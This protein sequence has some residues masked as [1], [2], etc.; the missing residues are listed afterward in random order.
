MEDESPRSWIS[1]HVTECVSNLLPIKMPC[2]I[3]MEASL[4]NPHL[5]LYKLVSEEVTWRLQMGFKWHRWATWWKKKTWKLKLGLKKQNS[6]SKEELGEKLI[7]N[8]SPQP[9]YPSIKC[10]F[11]RFPG[12]VGYFSG[13]WCSIALLLILN[14][15]KLR[16]SG[17]G[18][19]DR[20]TKEPMMGVDHTEISWCAGRLGDG[21][22]YSGKIACLHLNL[23]EPEK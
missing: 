18:G 12:G 4:W 10:V 16:E 13:C 9:N 20:R 6:L 22:P 11:Q 15:V 8:I 7:R 2:W 1:V 3:W 5:S 17:N 23:E 14:I 21:N 19:A